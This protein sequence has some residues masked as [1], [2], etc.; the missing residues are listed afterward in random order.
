MLLHAGADAN[1]VNKVHNYTVPPSMS[2][3]SSFQS[4][5]R[6]ILWLCCELINLCILHVQ[7]GNTALLIS[8]YMD[9]WKIV[10]ELLNAGVHI[11]MKN[12]VSSV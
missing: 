6:D 8:S 5:T 4:L 9:H 11:N 10:K 1:V 3:L 7:F 12:M 2:K